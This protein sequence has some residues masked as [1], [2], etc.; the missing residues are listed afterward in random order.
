MVA[1]SLIWVDFI[2]LGI[3]GVSV[4]ISLLRGFT[5]EAFSLVGWILSFWVA[6]SFAANFEG[7]LRSYIDT[8]SM[9]LITAFA[10]L[11]FLTLLF[12]AMLNFLAVQVIK[13]SGLSGTD[14]VVG[15][16]FGVARGCVIIAVLVMLA[17]LT[18]VPQDPWWKQS[19]LLHYFQDMA[20]WLRAYL[21]AEIADN[22]RFG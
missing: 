21:P 2:I 20:L 3:I 22:I 12:S 19:L 5:R 10:I 1:S 15:I 17:G 18:R 11:F 4:L 13:R 9:R 14:R 8:P 16:V 6:F 7:L